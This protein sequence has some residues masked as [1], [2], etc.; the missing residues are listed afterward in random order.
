MEWAEVD[1]ENAV[2]TIPGAKMKR[3]V[4]DK[5]N[6][7]AHIVPLSRQALAILRDIRPLTEHRRFVFPSVRGGDR[8]MS[9]MTL[10]GAL[11]RLGFDT[12]TDMTAHGFRAMARTMLAE[13]L[14]QPEAVIEALLAHVV[15]DGLGRAYNRTKFSDQRKELMQ[16]WS[17]YLDELRVQQPKQ[18]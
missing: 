1:F 13:R 11:Q 12:K 4:A 9:D 16:I 18:L 5:V 2:W 14:G 17:D 10:N 8:P 3:S 6:G 15:K 7:E